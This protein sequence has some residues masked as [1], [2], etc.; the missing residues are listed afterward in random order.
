MIQRDR[1]KRQLILLGSQILLWT[2]LFAGRAYGQSFAQYLQKTGSPT[3]AATERVPMGYVNV[4]NGNLHIEIPSVSIP[5][6]GGHAS[7][8]KMIYDSRIWKIVDDGSG[9]LMWVPTNAGARGWRYSS[10]GLESVQYDSV[11]NI[12]YD[13]YGGQYTWYQYQTI[14]I[15]T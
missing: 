6:R 2:T 10:T 11:A 7:V 1:N 9:G 12:C 4:A 3:L 15:Q 13:G 14:V 5:Q 8:A